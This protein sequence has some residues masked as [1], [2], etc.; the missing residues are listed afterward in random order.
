MCVTFATEQNGG[1]RQ[2]GQLTGSAQRGYTVHILYVLM[3][4]CTHVPSVLYVLCVPF[5]LY[6]RTVCTYV[7]TVCTYVRTYIRMYFFLIMCTICMYAL[8]RMYCM[9]VC[10]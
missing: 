1:F 5:I 7:R 10:M 2:C 6:V 9:Y 3:Y 4:V 8:I